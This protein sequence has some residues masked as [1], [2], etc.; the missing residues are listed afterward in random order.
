MPPGAV[1]FELTSEREVRS[2]KCVLRTYPRHYLGSRGWP[3]ARW[4]VNRYGTTFEGLAENECQRQK[5]ACAVDT[6]TP[7]QRDGDEGMM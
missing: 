1:L 7:H 3:E 2:A 5:K 6:H 4:V